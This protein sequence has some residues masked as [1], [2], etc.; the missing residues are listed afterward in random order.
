LIVEQALMLDKISTAGATLASGSDMSPTA[1]S[2]VNQGG[3]IT[4][5]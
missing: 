1:G 3:A 5:K 4:V 2:L